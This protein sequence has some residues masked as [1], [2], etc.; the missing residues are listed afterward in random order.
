MTR[1]SRAAVAVGALLAVACGAAFL[2]LR[3]TE[4]R[5]SASDEWFEVGCG[6]RGPSIG[7]F[8]AEAGCGRKPST[9]ETAARLLDS[10]P[11]GGVAWLAVAHSF[12]DGVCPVYDVKVSIDGTVDYA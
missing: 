10:A 8:T 7:R 11:D 1:G 3:H 6:G 2:A 5:K 9:V 12:C 4:A